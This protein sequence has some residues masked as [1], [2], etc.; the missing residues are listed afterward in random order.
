MS[1][2]GDFPG[3]E[4]LTTAEFEIVDGGRRMDLGEL[5][6]FVAE[7][8]SDRATGEEGYLAEKGLI[9]LPDERLQALPLEE[10]ALNEDG[11]VQMSLNVTIAD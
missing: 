10:V 2:A 9:P 4:A 3:I 5:E 6:D 8:L 11:L 1:G 7:F